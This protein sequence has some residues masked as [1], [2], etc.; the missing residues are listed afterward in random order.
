MLHFH[1][2]GGARLGKVEPAQ[3]QE[4]DHRYV[5]GQALKNAPRHLELMAGRVQRR[6]AIARIQALSL[7]MNLARPLR[8][9]NEIEA[10]VRRLYMEQTRA[11]S[12]SPGFPL[13]GNSVL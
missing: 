8:N 10:A 12:T 6:A 11:S 7:M 2:F 9:E 1:V 5:N 3:P 4:D 13:D